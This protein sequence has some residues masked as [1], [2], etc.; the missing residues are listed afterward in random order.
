M[1]K[2]CYFLDFERLDRRQKLK[3]ISKTRLYTDFS[4]CKFPSLSVPLFMLSWLTPAA[5]VWRSLPRE[6]LLWPPRNKKHP[7]CFL[8]QNISALVMSCLPI[9][10]VRQI[11]HL[12]GSLLS[13]T[14]IKIVPSQN[15]ILFGWVNKKQWRDVK[16]YCS[17]STGIQHLLPQKHVEFNCSLQFLPHPKTPQTTVLI[18]PNLI[19]FQASSLLGFSSNSFYYLTFCYVFIYILHATSVI[20]ERRGIFTAMAPTLKRNSSV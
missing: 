6:S 11:P 4:A 20:C 5:P 18:S 8:S 17:S 12:C 16:E 7:L 2:W 3:V 14:V 10:S 13:P 1:A 9:N 19:T 15:Q